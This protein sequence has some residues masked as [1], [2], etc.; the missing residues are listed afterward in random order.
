MND[1]SLDIA[2]DDVPKL[3]SEKPEASQFCPNCSAKLEQNHCKLC[4]LQCGFYLS[5]SDFY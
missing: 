1:H 2:T 3:T 4:C 5:C